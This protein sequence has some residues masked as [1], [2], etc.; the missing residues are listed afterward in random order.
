MVLGGTV[1]VASKTTLGEGDA[2]GH[3]CLLPGPTETV[4]T[5]RWASEERRR[6]GVGAG[7]RRTYEFM[8]S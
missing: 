2:F 7:G 5:Q 6:N 8:I 3:G 4:L 1:L